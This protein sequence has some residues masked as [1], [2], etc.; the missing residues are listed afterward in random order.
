[1]KYRREIDGLRAVAV[2]PVIFFHA[3]ISIFS[4]GYVGVDV[5][6]VISGYLITTILINELEAGD[7]SILRFYERRARRI[8]PALFVVMAPC[9]LW[10]WIWMSPALFRDFCQSVIAVI[11]FGSNILFWREAG[12]FD[13]AAELKPLLHTWSLAVEEQYYLLF[14]LFLMLLPRFG[15][16]K[17]FWSVI[18]IALIS[19]LLSEWAS[20]HAPEANFYLLPTRGWELLAGSICAFLTVGR[21][22]RPNNLLG[23]TGLALIVFSVFYYDSATPFPSLYALVPVGGTVLIVLFAQRETWAARIL[24][25]AP[26]VGVGVI[27]YSAYLWH[28][29][30]FAFARLQ[31][32]HEP[33]HALMMFLAVIT[34]GLAYLT[35]RFVE[36]PFRKRPTPVL[37]SQRSVFAASA[38]AGGSF[39]AL[40]AIL[41]QTPTRLEI[42]HPELF[43]PSPITS[44]AFTDCPGFAQIQVSKAECRV[45]GDGDNVAVVW[46]DSHG[47][48]LTAGIQPIDGYSVVLLHHFG[49]PPAAGLRRTDKTKSA[50]NCLTS[51]TLS[52]YL[53]YISALKP[54]AVFLLSRWTLYMQGWHRQGRLQADAHFVTDQPKGDEDIDAAASS[55]AL[56]RGVQGAI[57]KLASTSRV[58]V[59]SQPA[60]LN[61]MG[62]HS[63]LISQSVSVDD[64]KNW[65]QVEETF[66][67]NLQ[68]GSDVGILSTMSLFC[69]SDNCALRKEGIPLYNDDNHLS[70]LGARMQWEMMVGELRD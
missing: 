6:F 17:L 33:S 36:Q 3:G 49:C 30:L 20:R 18:G 41:L 24:S 10:A 69:T 12:Y 42:I 43:A 44:A 55:A 28:Q 4:G 21:S 61:F 31:S 48:A 16:Q 45:Y 37:A 70:P 46:G 54:E 57:N 38:L 26:L 27:S 35:W 67:E 47:A 34:L 40:A 32:P 8:L 64:I 66:L 25:T 2:L 39:V 65:H 52:R 53:D 14:P 11:F 19:L 9:A 22:V 60:D 29:P 23:L 62:P 15:R 50:D 7:F 51:D 56:L 1:M 58:F 59:V 63:R 5:F 68:D 13:S